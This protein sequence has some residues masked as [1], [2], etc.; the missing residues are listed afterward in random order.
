MI[1]ALIQLYIF[2][3]IIDVFLSFLPQLRGQSWAKAIRKAADLTCAPIRKVM[4]PDL[5][6]DF[7]PLIVIMAFQLIRFLW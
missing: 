7:S 4:P 1:R 2:V 5:P 3:L 6:F